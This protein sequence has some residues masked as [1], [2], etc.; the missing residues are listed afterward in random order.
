MSGPGVVVR[1]APGKLFV[2]GEYAVV[3]GGSPAVLVA[4]DRYVTVTLTPRQV[5]GVEISSDLGPAGSTWSW[6][7]TRLIPAPGTD[8]AVEGRL[9]HVRSAIETVAGLLAARGRGLPGCHLA[10]TS[11][12]HE[13][14]TKYGLGSSGAV[15]VAAIDA[16]CA[17]AGLDTDAEQ[18]FRLALLATAALDPRASGGDLAA[19]TW[20]GWVCYQAPDRAHLAR[21]A[22][23]DGVAAALTAPWPGLGLRTL[24]APAGLDLQVGWTGRPAS[25]AALVAGLDAASW[26]GGPAHERFVTATNDCVR[27]LVAALDG[28]QA[29]GVLQ[30]VDAAGRQLAVLDEQVG[31]GVFTPAL[32]ALVEAARQAGGAAKP[33]GAGGGDCG[34]ALLAAGAPHSRA[35]LHRAWNR[36]GVLPLPLKVA[37]TIAR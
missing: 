3:D 25:T 30:Q 35:W 11:T 29:A 31:L 20:G 36:A 27:A 33:S 21:L 32:R 1:R 28:G 26:R 19:S 5:P 10:V 14:G 9:A 22:A 12:L 6:A 15:T 24:T 23:R 34:I 18:R 4:V 37:A 13:G 8:P 2:A 17:F 7:G 16:L